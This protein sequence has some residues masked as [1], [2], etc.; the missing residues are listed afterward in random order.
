MVLKAQRDD[1]PL[2]SDVLKAKLLGLRFLLLRSPPCFCSLPEVK[3]KLSDITSVGNLWSP[4]LYC[5]FIADH[6]WFL[7]ATHVGRLLQLEIMFELIFLQC[8]GGKHRNREG[9]LGDN[10]GAHRDGEARV[11]PVRDTAA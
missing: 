5:F 10:E 1:L 2:R 9:Q 11:K 8:I 7:L 3:G 4:G 6:Q